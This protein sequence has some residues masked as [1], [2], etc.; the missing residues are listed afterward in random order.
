MAY[1]KTLMLPVSPNDLPAVQGWLQ[2]LA[3]QGLLLEACVSPEALGESL[4]RLKRKRLFFYTPCLLIYLF[5]M[6]FLLRSPSRSFF[7]KVLDVLLFLS[8]SYGAYHDL[9]PLLKVKDQA[10]DGTLLKN[11]FPY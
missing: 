9:K 10:L 6:L 8:I 3:V 5:G 2:G 1:R 7:R 11:R 4:E